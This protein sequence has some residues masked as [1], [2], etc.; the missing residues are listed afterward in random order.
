MTGRILTLCAIAAVIFTTGLA[1]ADEPTIKIE[2]TGSWTDIEPNTRSLWAGALRNPYLDMVE[3][4]VSPSPG[5]GFS[6]LKILVPVRRVEIFAGYEAEPRLKAYHD[7]S[8]DQFNRERREGSAK[9]EALDAGIVY[10][11]RFGS[12]F[13]LRPW[14]GL[15]HIRSTQALSDESWR[16]HQSLGQE[17]RVHSLEDYE[18]SESFWGVVYGAEAVFDFT[19]WIGM[20]GRA[21]QRWGS[22]T[23]THVWDYMHEVTECPCEPGDPPDQSETSGYD[24]GTKETSSMFGFDLGLRA[25]FARW[26]ALEGGWRYRYWSYDFGPG[27]YDGPYLRLALAF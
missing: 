26:V 2:L 4:G 15:T 11:F 3:A 23:M 5:F 20:S 18:S 19:N 21:F 12:R 6:E 16:N 22:G 7:V 25:T 1:G 27:I 14:A 13:H 24:I 17:F 9:V 10:P 8:P